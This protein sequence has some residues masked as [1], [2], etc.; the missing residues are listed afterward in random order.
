MR[1]PFEGA[2]GPP[3]RFTAVIFARFRGNP[4]HQAAVD[5]PRSPCAAIDDGLALHG[6]GRARAL[7]RRVH[8]DP[9]EQ[10]ISHEH[11]IGGVLP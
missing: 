1:E 5:E 10:R 4:L 11:L 9:F 8:A 7:L 2:S 6:F 3:I